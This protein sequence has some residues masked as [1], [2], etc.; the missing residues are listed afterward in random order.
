MVITT[1]DCSTAEVVNTFGCSF[2]ISMPTSFKASTTAGL[3]ES[4]GDEPA[5][6]TSIRS[7]AKWVK[8][9]AAICDRP[10]L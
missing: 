3:I 1:S 8:N 5:D 9:A 7:P 2:E 4:A 6:L 10:A